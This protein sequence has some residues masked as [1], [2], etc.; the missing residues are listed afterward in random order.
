MSVLCLESGYTVKYS[1][2]PREIPWALPFGFPLGSGYISPYIPPL[3]SIQIQYEVTPLLPGGLLS[4]N[5]PPCEGLEKP[6]IWNVMYLSI[7]PPWYTLFCENY[8]SSQNPMSARG[9][10][11]GILVTSTTFLNVL[12]VYASY[13]TTTYVKCSGPLVLN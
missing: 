7:F 4:C 1:R 9:C 5:E 2:S 3:I 13:F 11:F 10:Y 6:E 12:N 8:V